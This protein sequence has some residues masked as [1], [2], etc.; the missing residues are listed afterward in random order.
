MR[1]ASR[2]GPAEQLEELILGIQEQLT[3]VWFADGARNRHIAGA[4]LSRAE[5]ALT[6]TIYHNPACGTSR[7]TL[8]MIRERAGEPVIV[9][10]LKTP[11][12]RERLK[13]LLAAMGMKP[14][15]LLRQRGTPYAELGLDG[16][17]WTDDELI[18]FMVAHPVLIERPI[19]VTDK[20]ARLCRPAEKV[21]EI[22][23]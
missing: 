2:N 14:R 17:E 20:G 6:V 16:P 10:Y 5:T 4:P 1:P 7:N 8:A 22:L 21:L 19:V 11:P 3:A 12:G 15:E 13:E 9:E 23:P 18:G